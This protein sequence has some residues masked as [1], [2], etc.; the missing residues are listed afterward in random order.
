MP[1]FHWATQLSTLT[2]CALLCVLVP[3]ALAPTG[4]QISEQVLFDNFMQQETGNDCWHLMMDF[5]RCYALLIKKTFSQSAE[6]GRATIF[7]LC[8]DTTVRQGRL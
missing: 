1:L 2:P 4:A 3:V 7:N 8:N 5:D 6:A